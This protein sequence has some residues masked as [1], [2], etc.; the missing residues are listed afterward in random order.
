VILTSTGACYLMIGFWPDLRQSQPQGKFLSERILFHSLKCGEVGYKY[1]HTPWG[2]EGV[3]ARGF[4]RYARI[5]GGS[6]LGL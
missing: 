2:F 3:F 4:K 6:L 1:S 5:A